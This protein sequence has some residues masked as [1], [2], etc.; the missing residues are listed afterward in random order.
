MNETAE[1]QHEIVLHMRQKMQL[2]GVREVDSFDETGAV[3]HTVCG[4]LTVEGRDI[5]IGVLDVERGVVSL[6]GKIDGI[7]YSSDNTAEKKKLFHK[8]LR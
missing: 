5:H 6:T 2:N 3:F 1:H 8:L 4:E 7:Y